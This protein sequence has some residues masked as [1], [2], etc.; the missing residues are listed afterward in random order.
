MQMRAPSPISHSA[1][2]R[3]EERTKQLSQFNASESE[4]NLQLKLSYPLFITVESRQSYHW[5]PSECY[6]PSRFGTTFRLRDSQVIGIFLRDKG[7]CI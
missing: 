1:L 7:D 4:V 3:W 6:S 5:H 2:S